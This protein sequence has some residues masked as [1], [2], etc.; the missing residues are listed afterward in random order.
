[1][2]E[3]YVLSPGDLIVALTT[4]LAELTLVRI[5]ILVTSI[6]IRLKK[7]LMGRLRVAISANE[8]RM[9]AE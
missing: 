1:V 5:I 7:D 8:V 3:P 4:N 6:A 2:I 9:P